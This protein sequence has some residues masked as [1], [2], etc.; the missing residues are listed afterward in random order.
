MLPS[1]TAAK[2]KPQGL[3]Q[4]KNGLSLFVSDM[5]VYIYKKIIKNKKASI[6]GIFV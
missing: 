3:K 1:L 6:Q 4:E 2:L 5:I